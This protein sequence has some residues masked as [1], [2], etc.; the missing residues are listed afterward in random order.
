MTTAAQVTDLL[1]YRHRRNQ[2]ALHFDTARE[3][4]EYAAAQLEELLQ[5]VE[6][7]AL[8]V[9]TEGL[10]GPIERAL[11]IVDECRRLHVGYRATDQEADNQ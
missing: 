11:A 7:G 1:T 8:L 10:T 5:L 3:A 2:P 9:P 6:R 4:L